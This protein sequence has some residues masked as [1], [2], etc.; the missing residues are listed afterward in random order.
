MGRIREWRP[1]IEPPLPGGIL[2]GRLDNVEFAARGVE[3]ALTQQRTMP[4]PG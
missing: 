3:T 4:G 1:L 2:A